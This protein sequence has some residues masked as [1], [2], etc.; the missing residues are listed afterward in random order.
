[1]LE[2]K[3]NNSAPSPRSF[4]KV[5]WIRE[6]IQW[7]L[8]WLNIEFTTLEGATS[9]TSFLPFCFPSSDQCRNESSLK[10]FFTFFHY[11]IFQT[12]SCIFPQLAEEWRRRWK[13]KKYVIVPLIHVY[14]LLFSLQHAL[15]GTWCNNV[16]GKTGLVSV[17]QFDQLVP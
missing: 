14:Q 4:P 11:S 16:S 6:P 5:A 9:A 2:K 1:M 15:L 12:F 8:V 7:T 13:K 10:C 17:K 3:N